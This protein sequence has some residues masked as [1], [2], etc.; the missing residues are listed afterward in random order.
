MRFLM[1]LEAAAGSSDMDFSVLLDAIKGSITP[2]QVLIVLA[3]VIGVGM[4]FF[5][6]WLGARKATGAFTAA[7]SRGKIKI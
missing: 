4:S 1:A 3:A 7:V 6:M 2:Q 5:L